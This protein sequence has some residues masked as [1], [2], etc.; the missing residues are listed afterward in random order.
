[1]VQEHSLELSS[2]AEEG[3]AVFI[4]G[5]NPFVETKRLSVVFTAPRLPSGALLVAALIGPL[6]MPYDHHLRLMDALH[7]SIDRR[8]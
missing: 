4:N 8:G 1:M 3:P 2:Y 6:R 7:H 5:E